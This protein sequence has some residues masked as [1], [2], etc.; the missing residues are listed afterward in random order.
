VTVAFVFGV[1]HGRGQ[2]VAVLA[3][4]ESLRSPHKMDAEVLPHAPV[5]PL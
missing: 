4:T 3:R 1:V 5:D 2:F